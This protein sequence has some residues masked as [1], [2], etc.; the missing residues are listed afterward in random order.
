MAGTHFLD[1]LGDLEALGDVG[2]VVGGVEPLEGFL[3][4]LEGGFFG[5]QGGDVGVRCFTLGL[6]QAQGFVVRQARGEIAF[7]GVLDDAA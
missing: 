3:L 6:G 2:G 4:G 7:L 5:L 1:R